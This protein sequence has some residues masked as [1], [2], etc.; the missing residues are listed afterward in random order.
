MEP[1][2]PSIRILG[3]ACGQGSPDAR[4]AEGPEALRAAG[5]LER[6]LRHRSDSSWDETLACSGGNPFASI[7]R[8][9]ADLAERTAGAVRDGAMPLVLTGD[10]SCAVGVWAGV[11]R[12]LQPRGHLGL[13]W[14]DAHLDCHTAATSHTGAINGM[15]LA[16]LL[17]SGEESL[18]Q[19]G[20]PGAKILP[21][22]LCIV[23]ARSYEEEELRFLSELGVRVF[24]SDE[25]SRRGIG[26]VMRDAVELAG[27]G[28]AG[29]GLSI[30]ID[31]IDPREAPGVGTP[32]AGGI[33]AAELCAS[34]Q[35]LAGN[36]SLAAIEIS[37]YNPSRDRD[38]RTARILMQLVDA[39]L[40]QP[41]SA[42]R[43]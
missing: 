29:F 5:L 23:G 26:A 16:A 21:D 15:P 7:G 27:A 13:V 25:V 19:C 35:G 34:L 22:N 28:T 42:R 17:G 12:A 9:C 37:E 11:S 8:I 43:R 32:A 3:A 30:D 24:F 36:P 14:V 18:T 20:G 39:L 41:A 6:V 33:A 2:L 38:G 10:H 1:T 31:A 40:C 4:C